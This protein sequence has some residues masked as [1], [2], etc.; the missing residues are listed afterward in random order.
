M[1]YYTGIQWLS[2]GEVIFELRAETEIF[3]KNCAQ[4]LLLNTEWLWKSVFAA[5]LWCFLINQ[6]KWQGK[7]VFLY[8]I[9]ESFI[10]KTTNSWSQVMPNTFIL[11]SCCQK[12]KQEARPPF[13]YKF[14]AA[15]FLSLNYSSRSIL[16][17][18]VQVQSKCPYIKTHLTVQLKSFYLTFNGKWFICN[19]MTC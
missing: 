12:L 5:N 6:H 2:S 4:S 19:E 7:T 18:L 15:Y 17:S 10:S 9:F 13:P 3:V 11:F 14:V 8:K 16:L 1:Y